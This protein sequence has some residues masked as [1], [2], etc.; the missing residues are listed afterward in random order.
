M[1]VFRSIDDYGVTRQRVTS[2][3]HYLSVHF[4]PLKIRV[5]SSISS[6]YTNDTLDGVRL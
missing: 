1:G 6:P 4:Y 2:F 3:C 5:D